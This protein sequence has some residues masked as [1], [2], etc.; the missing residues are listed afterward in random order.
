MDFKVIKNEVIIFQKEIDEE[1][2]F[3]EED[4]EKLEAMEKEEVNSLIIC[5]NDGYTA[6]NLGDIDELK[7]NQVKNFTVNLK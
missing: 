3:T 2:D 4:D 7:F 6:Y 5:F 1:L